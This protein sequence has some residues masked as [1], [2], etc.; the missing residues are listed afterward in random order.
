LQ[1]GTSLV[2]QEVTNDLLVG[3]LEI[4]R[5]DK[6]VKGRLARRPVGVGRSIDI[7]VHP[8]RQHFETWMRCG[9]LCVCGG[10]G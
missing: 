1:D 5:I 8:V 4:V 6:G 7:N 2:V 10:S 3:T 9:R